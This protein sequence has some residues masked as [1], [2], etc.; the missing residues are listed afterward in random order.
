MLNEKLC[1]SFVGGSWVVTAMAVTISL[2]SLY[3]LLS[4]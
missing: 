1:S 3:R 4:R 2:E